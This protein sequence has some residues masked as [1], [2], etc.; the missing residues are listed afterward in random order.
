MGVSE[1]LMAQCIAG[2]VWALLAAQPLIIQSATGPVLVFEASLFVVCQQMHID[3]LAMRVHTRVA[4]TQT[5]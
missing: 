1:T 4:W 2:V 3:V 5:P